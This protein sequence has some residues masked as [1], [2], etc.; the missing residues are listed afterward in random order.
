MALALA[1]HCL[2]IHEIA[3][4]YRP[5]GHLKLRV[6]DIPDQYENG[7]C[8]RGSGCDS[9]FILIIITI[10]SRWHVRGLDLE[11]GCA[12]SVRDVANAGCFGMFLV[13]LSVQLEHGGLPSEGQE[14]PVAKYF[15]LKDFRGP[16]FNL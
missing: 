9:H 12:S 15:H 2:Q 1:P 8:H 3:S 14:V 6:N 5:F 16:W 7:P 13:D 10:I 11:L 4:E